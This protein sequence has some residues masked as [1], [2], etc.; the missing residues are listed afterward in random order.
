VPTLHIAQ[1]GIKNGDKKLLERMAGTSRTV[2]AWTV[3]KSVE[4]G[5]QVVLYIGG[6]G[7]FA[8]GRIM[9][10]AKPRVG[11][12]N[13]YGAAVGVIK[14]IRPAISLAAIRRHIPELK[15]AIYPRSIVTP[16]ADLASEIRS[17]I[18]ER[19]KTG[20]P[21]LTNEALESANIDE[22]RAV[23]LLSQKKSV[24]PRERKILYRARS[25]A[26]REY[27]LRRANGRCEACKALAPFQTDEGLPYLEAHHI[28]QLAD[29]GP[30]H[31]AKVIGVCPNCHS[32]AHHSWDKDVFKQ[33]L[34]KRM[35][36]LEPE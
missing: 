28:E 21:D 18:S 34:L 20:I 36:A 14:L 11:W 24:S 15:W 1:V 19:R 29:E 3:P 27:V 17:I 10:R 2:N 23:A 6:Y 22:L 7:F 8:T 5:D 30:D 13:R 12:K 25:V 9:T 32:R 35:R 4:I 16:S 33:S 26:I 31:P